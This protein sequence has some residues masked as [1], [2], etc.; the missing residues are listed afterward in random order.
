MRSSYTDPPI[1][2]LCSFMLGKRCKLIG[3]FFPWALFRYLAKLRWKRTLTQKH[4]YQ[5]DGTNL[6]ERLQI[7][8]R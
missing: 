2:L 3:G 7:I 8:K 5:N 6:L 4:I 1:G